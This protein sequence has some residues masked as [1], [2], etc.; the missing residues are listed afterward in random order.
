MASMF[1]LN[2][3]SETGILAT[4]NSFLRKNHGDMDPTETAANH[5]SLTTLR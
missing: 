1:R 5:E 2:K 4:M 3:G